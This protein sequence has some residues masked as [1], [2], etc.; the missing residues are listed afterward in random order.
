[1]ENS[2]RNSEL[3]M[4]QKNSSGDDYIA[5]LISA[6][7]MAEA[8]TE[9][10][11]RV[12]D[13][14]SRATLQLGELEQPL[15]QQKRDLADLVERLEPLSIELRSAANHLRNSI[16]P[17][18]LRIWATTLAIVLMTTL[19]LLGALTSLRPTWCLNESMAD[20]L[21]IG[22]LISERLPLLPK[23]RQQLISKAL[24]ELAS[25]RETLRPNSK[26]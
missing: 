13:Q 19:A 1:M 23:E 9:T 24:D 22:R 7:E 18:L 11:H 14:L 21:R 15:L 8:S 25:F 10:L 12:T 5:Q 2:F 17:P 4:Q 20:Q 3:P 26:R 16:K 6:I